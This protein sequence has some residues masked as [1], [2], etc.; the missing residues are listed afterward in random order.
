MSTNKILVIDDSKVIR[1]RVKDMLPEGNFNIIE[2][3]DGLEGFNLIKTE[4]PNLIM[5]DF[6]LPKMSGWEVYQEIQ[7]Q[8]QF[9]SIPLVLMS[10]RKEEVTDKLSE[11]FKYFSFVEKP[12]DREQ[13][14]S[15]IR[16]AMVKAK[17]Q[18][19][20]STVGSPS[21]LGNAPDIEAL[22]TEIEQLKLQVTNL[23]QE[24]EQFKKQF[25]QLVIF[26]KQKLK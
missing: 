6:L 2:A 26:V 9:R 15:A 11:P 18:P 8:H 22:T 10:G 3:K 17:K 1:M 4:N 21:A 5:L 12:F 23:K 14:V 20:T 7:K 25:N 16:D 19:Q 13:L 24:S